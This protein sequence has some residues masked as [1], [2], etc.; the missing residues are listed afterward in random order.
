[1][2]GVAES[3]MMES[4]PAESDALESDAMEGDV[5]EEDI[6]LA[7]ASDATPQTEGTQVSAAAER[8]AQ[9]RGVMCRGAPRPAEASGIFQIC[10]SSM[11]G[12]ASSR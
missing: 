7:A 3:D 1:M 2:E 9:A 12:A 4:D 11:V 6:G 5:A 8:R 10:S